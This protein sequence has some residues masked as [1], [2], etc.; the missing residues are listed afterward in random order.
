MRLPGVRSGAVSVLAPPPSRRSAPR[1]HVLAAVFLGGAAGTLVRA[2]L[3]EALARDDPASWPW[4]TFAVNVVGAFLVGW[5]S[6][7][8]LRPGADPR[9][10]PLLTTGLCGGLTTF[11]TL[12]VE[13]VAML[14]AD[15]WGVAV[16][17]ASVSVVLGLAAVS[18]GRR[19]A[20][21]GGV[22][23]PRAVEIDAGAGAGA[24]PGR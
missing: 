13:L 18:T 4:A 24:G 7:R 3:A 1:T 9:L 19:A 11:S 12:Q 17:Y 22:R 6:A 14:R 20:G 10:R 5:W 16:A 8:L 2:G 23:G 15:A 21:S